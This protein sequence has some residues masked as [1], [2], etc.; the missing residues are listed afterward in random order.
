[1]DVTTFTLTAL[2]LVL[3]NFFHFA[4]QACLTFLGNLTVEKKC[5]CP[6]H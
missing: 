6:P 3:I 4:I 2:S 5:V 1:M